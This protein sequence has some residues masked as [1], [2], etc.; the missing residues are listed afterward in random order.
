M[1]SA[2]ITG[3]YMVYIIKSDKNYHMILWKSYYL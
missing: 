1:I 2:G 3:I